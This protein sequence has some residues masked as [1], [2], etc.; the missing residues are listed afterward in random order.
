MPDHGDASA[1][2]T[3]VVRCTFCG[4]EFTPPDDAGCMVA[5]MGRHGVPQN[6]PRTL[7]HR[8]R[9]VVSFTLPSTGER[10]HWPMDRS[11]V[12]VFAEILDRADIGWE[13]H[14]G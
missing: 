7:D 14:H 8:I 6:F 5:I 1:S 3:T 10:W 11:N 4:E 9:S 12:D 13:V 2:Q